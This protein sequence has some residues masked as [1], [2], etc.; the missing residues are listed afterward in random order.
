VKRTVLACLGAAALAG[1]G[2]SSPG[3]GE[4]SVWITRDRGAH[5]I[6]VK[7]VPAG[8]TAME[9]LQRVADVKTRYGGRFV[10]SIN[11][12]S[13]NLSAQ[14]DWLYFINGYEADRGAADYELHDGDVEWWDY[15][16][17]KGAIHVPVVVGAFPEPFRHGY[18]GKTRKAALVFQ[19]R[20]LADLAQ[21][22]GKLIGADKVSQDKLDE[23][24]VLFLTQADVP[25]SATAKGAGAPVRFVIGPTAARRLVANPKRA[26]FRYEGL[27]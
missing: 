1:C 19:S 8:E 9:A 10:Q 22:L 18:D 21:K 12:V 25:F 2:S 6:V 5:V 3:K 26:R 7:K 23:A 13:G 14:R 15:R 27:R 17:W 24:N 20:G 11:G 4:A 16:N